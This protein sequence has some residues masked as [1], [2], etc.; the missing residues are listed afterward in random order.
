LCRQGKNE[1]ARTLLNPALATARKAL[2]PEHPETLQTMYVL[3]AALSGL[4][5]DQARA[6]FEELL[7]LRKRVSG[8]EHPK[9]LEAM[10]DLALVWQRS[11]NLEKARQLLEQVVAVA[12]RDQPN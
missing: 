8:P 4:G 2:G 7:A 3:A 12:L 10:N 5:I 6:R 11:G 9:T 1:E